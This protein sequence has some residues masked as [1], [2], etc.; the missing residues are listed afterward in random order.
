MKRAFIIHG[1]GGGPNDHWFPWL[2]KE[3]ENRGFSVITPTMPDTEHP[4]IDT[5]V[6]ELKKII[7][8]PTEDTYLIGHSIACQT[9][10]RYLETLPEQKKIGRV[11][12][13]AGFFNLP[14]LREEEI[15]I[16]E[17]WLKTPI[18]TEKVKLHTKNIIALFS[19]N[20]KDVPLS[21]SVIF[22]QRLDAKIIIE[23]NK[24]HFTADDG[25]MEIPS[26]LKALLEISEE[27]K[28]E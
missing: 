24:G 14:N 21:D 11:I 5:W 12:F 16:A 13:I 15:L 7:D 26:A 27:I 3:L 23:N 18:N 25:V 17:P 9:I 10:M 22:K 8:E 28:N 20:D 2:R 19:D 4:K 1:W 6:A